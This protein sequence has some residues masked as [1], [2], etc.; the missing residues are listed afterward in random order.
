M[1]K[2]FT[3]PETDTTRGPR[4]Q[5]GKNNPGGG[6]YGGK[7]GALTVQFRVQ[8]LERITPEKWGLLIDSLVA[9]AIA[10][11]PEAVKTVFRYTLGV[12]PTMLPPEKVEGAEIEREM[13]LRRLKQDNEM[14]A[15]MRSPF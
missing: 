11:D 3:T 2:E 15:R 4:G 9:R 14:D 12:P 13:V 8:M 6:G 1:R 10:G 5:F 7:I